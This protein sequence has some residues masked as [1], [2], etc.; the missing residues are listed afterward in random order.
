MAVIVFNI[1]GTRFAWVQPFVS[2]G[3]LGCASGCYFSSPSAESPIRPFSRHHAVVMLARFA[4]GVMNPPT[5]M[6]GPRGNYSSKREH[7]WLWRLHKRT[8]YRPLP[9]SLKGDSRTR[10]ARGSDGF[11]AS[12][13]RGEKI[14]LK[15]SASIRCS[16][17][18]NRTTQN[19]PTESPVSPI[20]PA[21]GGASSTASRACS[22]LRQRQT[23]RLARR[24]SPDAKR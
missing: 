11:D 17:L 16:L 21:I 2:I 4:Y 7:P 6:I 12:I 10:R 14:T 20:S 23:T 9:H 22:P 5:V 13:S 18:R 3:R 19:F 24:L 15:S 8:C 1:S